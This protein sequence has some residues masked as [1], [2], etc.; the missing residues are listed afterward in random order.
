VEFDASNRAIRILES[1]GIV[2]PDE[3]VGVRKTLYAAGFTY[4]AAALVAVVE[5]LY[6]LMRLG[7]LGGND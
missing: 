5:L 1:S 4:V 3:M 2:A 7:V 6:W